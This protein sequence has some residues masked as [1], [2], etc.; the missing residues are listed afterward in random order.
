M[1]GQAPRWGPG[2][3]GRE[4]GGG[5]VVICCLIYFFRQLSPDK[6]DPKLPG[7]AIRAL[8]SPQSTLLRAFLKGYWVYGPSWSSSGYQSV[9]VETV[10]SPLGSWDLTRCG[11][12]L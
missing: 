4:G 6:P 8:E 2:R 5:R 11:R 7:C 3:R 1:G 12:K 9:S 10:V